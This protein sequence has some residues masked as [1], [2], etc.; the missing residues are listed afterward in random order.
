MLVPCHLV[1]TCASTAGDVLLCIQGTGTP[2]RTRDVAMATGDAFATSSVPHAC[3][4]IYQ[5]FLSCVCEE[6]ISL[7]RSAVLIA[8]ESETLLPSHVDWPCGYMPTYDIITLGHY[9][10]CRIVQSFRTSHTAGER[11]REIEDYL[12][13]D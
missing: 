6:I 5:W 4:C 2:L 10:L 11:E 8:D 9:L 1:Y 12:D 7:A 13:P 3:A